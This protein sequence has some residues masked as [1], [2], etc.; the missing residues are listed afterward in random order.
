[1][2]TSAPTKV[3]Y[4]RLHR[5]LILGAI[6]CFLLPAVLMG[7][8]SFLN[9]SEFSITKMSDFFKRGADDSRKVIDLFLEER[10]ADLRLLAFTH[11]LTF[12][13][14]PA[15]LREAFNVL[16]E[17]GP[18]FTDLGVIDSTGKHLAYV[19]PY[20]LMD[21]DYSKTFWF[22]GVMEKGVYIS[23][24]FLGYREA[25]HFIIAVLYSQADQKWILRATIDNEFLDALI[26][27]SRLGNTGEVF[28]LNRQGVFQTTSRFDG[29][30]MT[31][32]CL[33]TN[34][35]TSETGIFLFDSST[36]N[37][38]LVQNGNVTLYHQII[39]LLIPEAS[40]QI[41]AFSN[42]KNVNWVLILKQDFREFFADLH[43]LL[44]FLL[45]IHGVI[46][47]IMVA[48]V[49][50]ARH[51]IKAIDK[52]E[53]EARL[54]N[55]QLILAG[56]LAAIGE[57]A[58]GV[59]HEINNPLAVILTESM[60][61]REVTSDNGTLDEEFRSQLLHSTLQIDGQIE[62]CSQITK[63]L[64]KLARKAPSDAGSVDI[65]EVVSNVV[66][67]L[68]KMANSKGIQLVLNLNGH[69]PQLQINAF[70]LEE[71]FL[72]LLKNA[73]DASEGKLS[74]LITITTTNNTVK[75]SII[76]TVADTG[77]GISDENL[78]HLFEPFFTTKPVDKGTGLGLSISYSI[79]RR[80]GGD[81]LVDS[82]VGLGTTFTIVL[83]YKVDQEEHFTVESTD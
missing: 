41:I 37:G 31:K 21:K 67:L 49:L 29:N 5:R 60:I 30:V 68:G 15:N 48:A 59:A 10:T 14:D 35:F 17:K 28:L 69:L 40:K 45:L 25:P 65:D 74:S 8:L 33:P 77:S 61:I 38:R 79:V 73:V 16:N 51:M 62:R 20:D 2:R 78:E 52:K 43:Q 9:Y 22:K 7:W 34:L 26:D 23:D 58:S 13:R 18:Y 82:Q 3:S 42:L 6:V 27:S 72:N 19:G 70:E 71:V 57:L 4:S 50:A 36:R 24:M 12:L 80:M 32:T 75:N 83:P 63:R 54:L 66:G 55:D 47:G 81:I 1:M 44:I 53:E 76:A 56:K 39:A 11:S 46:L 64:L